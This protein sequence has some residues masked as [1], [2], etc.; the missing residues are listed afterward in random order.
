MPFAARVDPLRK[1]VV[2]SVEPDD[3][4][5]ERRPRVE[6]ALAPWREALVQQPRPAQEVERPLIERDDVRTCQVSTVEESRQRFDVG[7]EQDLLDRRRRPR[8]AANDRSD[9]RGHGACDD[10]GVLH[11]PKR[12]FP[13]DPVAASEQL[14]KDGRLARAGRSDEFEEAWAR[15]ARG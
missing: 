11:P 14:F 4:V 15:L 7:D 13:L 5:E 3:N 12:R 8:P 1:D 2:T 6:K 9:R 10:P